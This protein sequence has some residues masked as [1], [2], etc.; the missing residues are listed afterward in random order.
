MSTISSNLTNASSYGLSSP[1]LIA[2][3][4]QRLAA[5][6]PA[7]SAADDSGVSGLSATA[8][9][10]LLQAASAQVQ[11]SLTGLQ[12]SGSALDSISS[13][14]SQLTQAAKQASDPSSDANTRSA[15]QDTFTQLQQQLR[16]AIGGPASVIGGDS[17]VAGTGQ[18]GPNSDGSTNPT[19]LQ[20]GPMLQLI[21]QN[22]DGSFTTDATSAADDLTGATEQVADARHALGHARGHLERRAMELQI[23]QQNFSSALPPLDDSSANAANLAA[24]QS[25]LDQGAGILGIQGAPS[26]SAALQALQL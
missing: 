25:I 19:N 24:S 10:S 13:L 1:D 2:R 22:A 4:L 5:L 12:S 21:A 7:D 14:L 3:S 8:S 23:E 16:D 15:A 6:A 18:F 9:Q 20:K 11:T 17:D 26:A